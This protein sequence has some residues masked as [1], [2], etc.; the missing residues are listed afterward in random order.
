M[1]EK[2]EFPRDD[3]KWA[4]DWFYESLGGTLAMSRRI[5]GDR[6]LMEQLKFVFPNL[7]D[8][9]HRIGYIMAPPY[10]RNK[11]KWLLSDSKPSETELP[12]SVDGTN[13]GSTGL[14]VNHLWARNKEHK[15]N[16]SIAVTDLNWTFKV[17][18]NVKCESAPKIGQGRVE[19][20]P[21]IVVNSTTSLD[22]RGVPDAVFKLDIVNSVT[23]AW[24]MV[25]VLHSVETSGSL[26]VDMQIPEC[27]PT[28]SFWFD[29]KSLMDYVPEL[30]ATINHMINETEF[31][32]EAKALFAKEQ[33]KELISGFTKVATTVTD[34]LNVQKNFIFPGGGTFDMK[35]PV[36]NKAGDLMIGLTYKKGNSAS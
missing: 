31:I 25:L 17:D 16:E 9:A 35:S 1:T 28:T 2:R 5:F 4:S 27:K 18:S 12:T 33:A 29:L 26:V 36:F 15:W 32:A 6:F 30:K 24:P 10:F 3:L 23:V 13:K 7:V 8:L 11:T 20:T 22:L 21:K 14:D 34:V 19:I